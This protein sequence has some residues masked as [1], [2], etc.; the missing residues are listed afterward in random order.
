MQITQKSLIMWTSWTNLFLIQEKMFR[1]YVDLEGNLIFEKTTLQKEILKRSH[2]HMGGRV[3]KSLVSRET[4]W[5]NCRTRW[6]ISFPPCQHTCRAR[7]WTFSGKLTLSLR[8]TFV[9]RGRILWGKVWLWTTD[10][11]SWSSPGHVLDF[12]ENSKHFAAVFNFLHMSK[13]L[14]VQQESTERQD[15]YWRISGENEIYV[16][17]SLLLRRI[18]YLSS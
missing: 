3:R 8:I 4:I 10:E 2:S 5:K 15:R 7:W 9:K 16:S 11:K 14:L 1:L 17:L 18:E 13:L 12:S 6:K